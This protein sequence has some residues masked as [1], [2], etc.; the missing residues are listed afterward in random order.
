MPT[1]LKTASSAIVTT[2]EAKAHM[3]VDW[4]SE[5]D[6]IAALVLQSQITVEERTRRAFSGAV[7]TVYT[8]GRVV[9]LDR[10]R[11]PTVVSVKASDDEEDLVT[12]TASDY[13]VSKMEAVPQLIILDKVDIATLEF[14]EVEYS[15][16]VDVSIEPMLKICV[17]Q[18]C[19]HWFENREA[20]SPIQL[21]TV[22]ANF[23]D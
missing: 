11:F 7:F 17:L 14:V 5:D 22:P 15:A 9:D 18:L 4:S 6:L 13:Y 23:D 20:T 19:A 12:L 16:G 2:A 1:I 3:R 21:R 8:T 10:S